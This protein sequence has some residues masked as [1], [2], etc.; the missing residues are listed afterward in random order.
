M[1]ELHNL[2]VKALTTRMTAFEETNGMWLVQHDKEHHV[3]RVAGEF[4]CNCK[5]Y[6]YGHTCY[7]V[8]RLR[9]ELGLRE[10]PDQLPDDEIDDMFRKWIDPV[11]RID[12]E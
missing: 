10:I 11:P 4:R 12:A 8:R 5:G 1:D 7:H 2:D 9:F 6:Q 3:A